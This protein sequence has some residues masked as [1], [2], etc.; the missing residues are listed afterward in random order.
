MSTRLQVVMSDVELG[1]IRAAADRRRMNV[2][3]WVRMVLR[4]ERDREMRGR[5]SLVAEPR[6]TYGEPPASLGT[7]A[8]GSS[9][10]PRTRVEVDV[11][12]ELLD[13][14]RERYRLPN[15]RAAIEFALRRVAV[16]PMSKEEALAMQ[17]VGWEGD[18]ERTRSAD[19]GALW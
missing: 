18:V 19:P 13:A 12:E 2:S 16:Q 15:R 14:V 10:A 3:E 7:G 8:S 6:G 1:E 9:P 4:E 17:G 5:S 11:K